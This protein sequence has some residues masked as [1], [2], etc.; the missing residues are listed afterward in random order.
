[1]INKGI[2]TGQPSLFS[3][4]SPSIQHKKIGTS[5]LMPTCDI[6]VNDFA[7]LLLSF[8]TCPSQTIFCTNF[9]IFVLKSPHEI[10]SRGLFFDMNLSNFPNLS[11]CK[12]FYIIMSFYDSYIPAKMG[13]GTFKHSV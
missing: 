7:T 1:M 10:I 4:S 5:M 11:F 13:D 3:K 12:L 2:N 9:N 8:I 6:I